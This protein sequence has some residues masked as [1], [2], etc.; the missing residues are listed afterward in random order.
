MAHFR[1]MSRYRVACGG[2]L[3]GLLLLCA[4]GLMSQTP[5]SPAAAPPDGAAKLLSFTGQISVLRSNY[6]WA[7]NAGDFVK[8]QE[9][10]VTGPDGWGVFQ[11]ADGSTFEVFPKSRVVFRANLGDWRDL[12][13]VWLGKVRVQIEHFGGVPNNNKVSTPTAVI[14]VRG[15]IFT[16]EVDDQAESTT[17]LDEEGSVAVLH[18]LK[19]GPERL[20]APGESITVYKNVPLA[21]AQIDKGGVFQKMMR[22]ASDAFYQAALNE[23]NGS[24][25]VGHVGTAASSAGSAADKNNGSTA[26]PP[27]PTPTPPPH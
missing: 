19:T 18:A 9:V 2:A 11:V 3:P 14:S 5:P 24:S 8:R 17:V 22:A 20:L 13:E 21:K 27:P 25:A 12:L 16:V 7:L 23:R 26:P 15:T 6:A 4:L 10:I 1:P